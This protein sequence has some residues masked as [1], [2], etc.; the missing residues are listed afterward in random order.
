MVRDEGFLVFETR[1]KPV[2]GKVNRKLVKRIAELLDL[3][4][5]KVYIVS[6][7]FSR[8]KVLK[9]EGLD[10]GELE[11]KISEKLGVK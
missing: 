11:R 5:D 6:G 8:M 2:K 4:V 3:S 9:V 7:R 10:Q 1:E